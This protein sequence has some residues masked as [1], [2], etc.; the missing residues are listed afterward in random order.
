[1]SF[2]IGEARHDAVAAQHSTF[3][4]LAEDDLMILGSSYKHI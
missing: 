4:W 2:L 1:M 3:R